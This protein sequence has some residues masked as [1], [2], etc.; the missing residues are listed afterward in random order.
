M[1]LRRT[2]CS[3]ERKPGEFRPGVTSVRLVTPGVIEVYLVNCC[4]LTKRSQ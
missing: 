3:P 2:Y 4:P 1:A